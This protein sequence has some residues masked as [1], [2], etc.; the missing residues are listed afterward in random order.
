MPEL[1]LDQIKLA[2]MEALDRALSQQM[3]GEMSARL[4]SGG[5]PPGG[6]SESAEFESM[7]GGGAELPPEGL[8][9]ELGE[10]SPLPTGAGMPPEEEEEGPS[11]AGWR[12]WMTRPPGS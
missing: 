9:G 12:P 5:M 11:R 10:G 4:G 8:E 6:S 3:G 2:V 7:E 1:D